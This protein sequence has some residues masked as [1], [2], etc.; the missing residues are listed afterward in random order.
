MNDRIALVHPYRHHCYHSMEGILQ[1]SNNAVALLGYFDKNDVLD[2]VV[3]HTSAAKKIGGYS[4][5]NIEKNVYTN[6]LIKA[7]FLASKKVPKLERVY[8][9]VF[10]KWAI[11]Q[12]KKKKITVVH[13][14]QDYCN[15]VIYYCYTHGIKVV[16]EQIQPFDILQRNVMQK[17][18][19]KIGYSQEQIKFK[20]EQIKEKISRQVVNLKNAE[21][22]ICASEVT[23][24]SINSYVDSNKCFTF[25]YGSIDSDYSKRDLR[26]KLLLKKDKIRILYVGQFNTLKGVYYIIEAAKKLEYLKDIEFLMIGKPTESADK[27]LVSLALELNNVKYIPEVPHT[28][29][30]D[31]Y[32]KCDIFVFQGLCEG[33]GMVTLEAMGFGLPCLVSKGGIGVVSDCE[34]GFVNENCDVDVLVSNILRLRNEKSELNMMSMNAFETAKKYNWKRFAD[35]IEDVYNRIF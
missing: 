26:E 34:N 24:Q 33:F 27:R 12:I 22:I 8:I 14:L 35:K 13:V 18:M 16:Y 31:L 5:N 10:E 4:N 30:A 11:K 20:T 7:L 15:S 21:T 2:R 32:K 1:Y 3:R 23:K 9:S 29:I 25:P 17:E 6:L 28:E 19:A